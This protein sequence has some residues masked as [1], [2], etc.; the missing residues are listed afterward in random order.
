MDRGLGFDA[1]AP[2]RFRVWVSAHQRCRRAAVSN[3]SLKNGA[4]ALK[5]VTKA[6]G[7]SP[8]GQTGGA[9]RGASP[10]PLP[11][12]ASRMHASMRTSAVSSKRNVRLVV[13]T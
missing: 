8:V 1:L 10:A 6:L 3:S 13:E 11:R 7:T 9:T 12:T 5:Q 4:T 2:T